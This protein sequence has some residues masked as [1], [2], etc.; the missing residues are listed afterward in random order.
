[1]PRTCYGT[2]QSMFHAF[3]SKKDQIFYRLV[4]RNTSPHRSLSVPVNSFGGYTAAEQKE[5]R[6]WL[7]KFEVENIPKKLCEVTFSRSSGPGG[8]NVNK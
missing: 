4:S 6:V 2:Q 5:A 1:M 3:L 7:S 8:Q